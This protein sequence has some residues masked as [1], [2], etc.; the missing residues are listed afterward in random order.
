[1]ELFPEIGPRKNFLVPPKFGARS[2]PMPITTLFRPLVFMLEFSGQLT[3]PDR[4]SY[5]TGLEKCGLPASRCP[6]TESPPKTLPPH[7]LVSLHCSD[8]KTHTRL[9]IVGPINAFPFRDLG[10][11]G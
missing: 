5:H 9:N 4:F 7:L 2:P 11:D 10:G 3:T 8:D 6:M 1:M